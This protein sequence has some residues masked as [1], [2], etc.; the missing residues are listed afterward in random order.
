M[1]KVQTMKQLG[2]WPNRDD[3]SDRAAGVKIS[4]DVINVLLLSGFRV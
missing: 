3:N 4:Q 1:M 2:G